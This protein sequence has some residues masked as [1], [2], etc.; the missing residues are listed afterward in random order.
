MG[1]GRNILPMIEIH[2]A[3]NQT[4]YPPYWSCREWAI[5]FDCY[6]RLIPGFIAL[7]VLIL[8]V[9]I[10]RS[11]GFEEN[12]SVNAP[13]S[14]QQRG[15]TYWLVK[16]TEN[17]SFPSGVCCVNQGASRDEFD[18]SNPGYAAWQHYSDSNLWALPRLRASNPGASRLWEDG[19]IFKF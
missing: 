15:Q 2:H 19:V 9:G 6:H 3:F 14:I 13:F 4:W 8:G 7:A 1:A 18:S 10:D 16:P 11:L 5:R 17:D 12:R